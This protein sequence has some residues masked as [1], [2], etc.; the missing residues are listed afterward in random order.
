MEALHQ[1]WGK[2][3]KP[4]DQ[5][6]GDSYHLLAYHS[7]DVAAVGRV[8]LEQ[9]PFLLDRLARSMG[10]PRELAGS[11]C[12]FL[13]GLHDL[14][15]YAE[16][17]QQLREDLRKHFW[18]TEKIRKK[19][20]CI[21]HDSLGMLLW[22]QYLQHRLF[23][24]PPESIDDFL[25]DVLPDWLAAVFGHHGW[26]PDKSDR[27]KN[28]FRDF[29]QQA[30]LGYCLDWQALMQPDFALVA[31]SAKNEAW[32]DRQKEASWLLAGVAVLADWLGSNQ[33]IFVFHAVPMALEKY[34]CEYA[35]PAANKVIQQAGILPP[36]IKRDQTLQSLFPYIEQPTPLQK[37]CAELAIGS[38]PQLFI[39]ED[40]TGAGKTE[41]AL[42]LAHRLIGAGL[43]QG[44]Y[45]G[46]PTM[47]T[48]NAMYERMLNT[49]RRFYADDQSPSLILS[50]SARRLSEKFQQSLLPEQVRLAP[51]GDEE[52][53]TAQ[54]NRWLADNRKKALL[55]DV[56]IGTI[57]QALLAVM[58]ARHQSLRLLGLANKVL[59]LDEVHAYDAYTAEPLK[60]LLQFHAALGGSVILLSATLSQKQRQMFV[61]A[62]YGRSQFQPQGNDYPLLTH[63]SASGE[64]SE[65][66][67]ETRSSVKRSVTVSLCHSEENV[68]PIIRQAVERGECVCWIRNTVGDA[69]DAWRQLS[70]QAWVGS[71]WLHLFHSRFA[72]SDRIDIEQRMLDLFGKSSKPEQRKGQVLVATQVV[73]QSLDLDFDAMIS[74]LAPIDL[75]IQRAG[76]LHRHQRGER[77][78]PILRVLSPE[79]D[80]NP[81]ADWYKALFPKGNFVYPHTLLLWRT[82]SILAEKKGWRMPDDAREL[83]EYVYDDDGECP[84]GLEDAALQADGN[85]LG[86][87]NAGAFASLRLESGYRGTDRWDE[88]ARIA[89]RLGEDTQTIYL[90][91]WEDGKLVPW[92]NEGR[93]C[94]DL[95]SMRVN[96]VQL[97][98][99]VQSDDSCLQQ[100][101]ED[102]RQDEKLFDE[103][104]FIL[105]LVY[106]DE[107]WKGSGIDDGGRNV[108]VFYDELT[109]LELKRL[110]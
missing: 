17:F 5:E 72:M 58:P 83:L 96:R 42:V 40:V 74:D 27:I 23:P 52:D 44:L 106:G 109:G 73:E 102:L 7:L 48:A 65:L 4:E 3:K 79:P 63:A 55:A 14:G 68:F 6:D 62:F 33:G 67:L 18:P 21:R 31:E 35:L 19:G 16:N 110:Q 91:R 76:R 90:A 53:I 12:V 95:S 11:W 77:G 98:Q 13:L 1:Y 29:D 89:T 56:G 80:L 85:I 100:A 93:Y 86:Q 66:P 64:T 30:A 8:L 71:D 47:A 69:R 108:E 50:H 92:K 25:Q 41:A 49:Y 61:N 94:W 43:A 39:L 45:I 51:Y 81:D 105:P 54:C 10:L 20:Y 107:G 57:D 15:K 75:L 104:S 22:Q 26:P 87:K 32:Q 24:D 103:H 97:T 82:A 2:A 37:T 99:L 84:A 36:S 34:W 28:H 70:E 78:E 38:E 46:L 9:H 101:L 60:K 88:E 59:I